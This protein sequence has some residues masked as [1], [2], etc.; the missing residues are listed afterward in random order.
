MS[1]EPW[2]L[3]AMML[4]LAGYGI[5]LAGL[6]RHLVE[7]SRASWLIWA[8][9]TGIEA[10]TYLAVNPGKPQGLVFAFSAISCIVVTLAMWRRS[11]WTRPSTT[12]TVCMAASLAAIILWLPLKETFWAHMLVVAAV[13][14]G[15]W[16]TWASVWEDRARERSPA[17][18][19]WTLGDLAALF[20]AVRSHGFG[21]GEYAYIL[22]ELLCHA[23]VWAMVGL[24]TIS[25][26]RALDMR[27][28]GRRI[29]DAYVPANPFA[30]R[31]THLG[32][33]VFAMQ[34][35]AAGETMLRFSGPTVPATRVPGRL[36]G[37][38]DRFL[39]I[40]RDRYM[41]PSGRIDDLINHSCAP[42]AGLRF[43]DDG[44]FLVALATIES[45][46]EVA[47]DYS[48][49]LA[50]GDWSMA[51]ACGAPGC[52]GRIGPFADLPEATQRR[53]RALGIVAPYLDEMGSAGRAERAA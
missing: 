47:W 33:A 17:W 14:L 16:P 46:E 7:P 28:G 6:R 13:P 23:S 44:V 37:A 27:R 18:G 10:A 29:L 35:F 36:S 26:L 19:L 43:T 49:T 42:N 4:S 9:A 1:V 51:C 3:V 2:F 15:F 34:G 53:Y 20:V 5:Y 30:V 45:G 39:Q 41:G 50:D 24:S 38:A 40:A 22:V 32:K 31:E 48:T 8:V 12:E 11:R 52:R 25:P 21:V